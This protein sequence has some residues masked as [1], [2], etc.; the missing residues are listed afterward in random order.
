MKPLEFSALRQLSAKLGKDSLLV[1]AAGGNTSI[2]HDGLMWI[3]A[4]GTWLM[5]A[6]E[7]DIFV[8]VD[9]VELLR[10][11]VDESP[12]CESCATFV[13]VDLNP[14]GLRPSIE[15]SVHALMPQRVVLHVH[16]VNT[17]ALA[18]RADAKVQFE[19][20]L[21][22]E[23]W[24]FVP[25]ARP[26]LQLARAINSVIKPNTNI[27]ILQNHGLVVAADS[28]EAA[29]RLLTA[30]V[31]KLHCAI[32]IIPPANVAELARI[33]T[34]SNYRPVANTIAHAAAMRPWSADLAPNHVYYPDHV[35][36]LGTTI[37]DDIESG[38]PAVLLPDIG[39]LVH[40]DA[41]P[42]IE[43]MLACLGDVFCRIA[44]NTDLKA[45]TANEI[46][47]LLNWD[48]EKYRQTLR[49]D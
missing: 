47:Q 14:S 40:R 29:E 16:C 33:A 15:T 43:P 24:A 20:R 34:T 11:L 18:I 38:A 21:S 26:G 45:L 1:Q 28:V 31:K 46:D 22:G 48:A 37:S 49:S 41:K 27:L 2:K 9:Q 30:V 23:N 8:P 5:N 4:S 12:D 6:D 42:S 3:K 36:F 19:L 17:I 10:A 13:R 32:E 39:V 35:V 25:Y 44:A 7:K